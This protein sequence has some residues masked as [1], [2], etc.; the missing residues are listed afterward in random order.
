MS[1]LLT[2]LQKT[3]EMIDTLT[4]A[5]KNTG[6]TPGPHAETA[7]EGFDRELSRT[8]TGGTGGETPGAGPRAPDAIDAELARPARTTAVQSIRGSREFQ[9]FE[10]AW[11][12]GQIQQ[13]ALL[14]V[15]ALVNEGLRILYPGIAL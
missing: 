13:D 2:E 10:R 8:G 15:L 3:V 5:G 14:R 6:E 7:G 12:D 4:A 11:I 9:E 1:D